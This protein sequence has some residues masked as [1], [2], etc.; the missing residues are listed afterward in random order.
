MNRRSRRDAVAAGFFVGGRTGMAEEQPE[1]RAM[2]CSDGRMRQCKA[3]RDGWTARKRRIFLDH[4]AATS[5]AT[6]S[7]RAAGMH[8]RSAF[9]LRR[10]DD[11]FAEEWDEALGEYETR[12]EGKLVVYA[13]SKGEPAPD[14]DAGSDIDGFDPKLAVQALALHRDRR[15]GGRR[16]RGGPRPRTASREETEAAVL[17]LL[18]AVAKRSGGKH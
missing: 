10:R 11:Q 5:N 9:A 7:A 8:P 15:S 12:L 17:K 1:R 3:R 2:R 6:D 18:K 13:E 14:E 16:R 4:L